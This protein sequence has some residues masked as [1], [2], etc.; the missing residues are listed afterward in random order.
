MLYD[1]NDDRRNSGGTLQQEEK[2]AKKAKK[3]KKEKKEKEE[4]MQ[5]IWILNTYLLILMP[6]KK[7]I[8]LGC[9]WF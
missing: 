5:I 4:N 9:A 2:K 8:Q 3:E 6:E 1:I 7:H